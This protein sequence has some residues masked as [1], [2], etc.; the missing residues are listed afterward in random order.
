MHR[1][2]EVWGRYR[3]LQVVLSAGGYH[4]GRRTERDVLLRKEGKD[5]RG[6]WKPG[7]GV[8]DSLCGST[9]LK[10][11]TVAQQ[12]TLNTS[13][14]SVLPGFRSTSHNSFLLLLKTQLSRWG[15]SEGMLCW[16]DQWQWIRGRYKVGWL[17]DRRVSITS[18][19][20]KRKVEC[21]LEHVKT[22]SLQ[23]IKASGQYPILTER[24]CAE[25]QPSRW[26]H[27]LWML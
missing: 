25:G 21:L 3:D 16:M 23:Y 12:H 8:L 22:L 10:Q 5:C 4:P 14:T 26:H 11:C 18:R 17:R 9:V 13:F 19:Q 27:Y 7:W 1:S 15:L 2:R 20:R 24:S 6:P